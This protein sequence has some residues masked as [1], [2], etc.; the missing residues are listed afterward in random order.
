MLLTCSISNLPPLPLGTCFAW[1]PDY[2]A[3]QEAEA[4]TEPPAEEV[5]EEGSGGGEEEGSGRSL[6]YVVEYSEDPT[7]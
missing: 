6:D 3:A 4:A 5:E 1:D 7:F 2:V